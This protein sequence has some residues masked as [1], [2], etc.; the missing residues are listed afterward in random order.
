MS[1]EFDWA[2]FDGD[3][4]VRPASRVVAYLNP[5]CDV[6]LRQERDLVLNDEDVWIVI[7][8]ERVSALIKKLQALTEAN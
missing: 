1:D 7:P 4:I 3:E 2:D 8:K 6:V 5:N